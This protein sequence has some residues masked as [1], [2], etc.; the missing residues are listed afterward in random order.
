MIGI[1][2]PAHVIPKLTTFFFSPRIGALVNWNNE[3]R[4]AI[5]ELQKM[6]VR[7]FHGYSL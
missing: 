3:L 1:A 5:D 2:R 6:G 4:G 7:G